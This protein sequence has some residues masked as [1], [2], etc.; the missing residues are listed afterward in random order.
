[1]KARRT[2][3]EVAPHMIERGVA[4]GLAGLRGGVADVGDF[5]TRLAQGVINSAKQ[6]ARQQRCEQAAG[7]KHDQICFADGRQRG[8][9]QRLLA[10]TVGGV[11]Q[12]GKDIV[13]IVPLDDSLVLDARVQPRD[14]AFIHPGQ[15]ANVKFTAYDF[16]IYGGLDAT[17]ENI[18]PDT[19]IDEKGNAEAPEEKLQELDWHSSLS[20]AVVAV[21]PRRA[22]AVHRPGDPQAEHRGVAPVSRRGRRGRLTVA[23]RG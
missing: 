19:V 8:R 5:P 23:I 18:S 20:A 3:R 13:E 12:P 4:I 17:V 16:S 11:V 9:V 7:A 6:Q 15:K 1:M 21:V 2:A 22:G 14:I 10:N